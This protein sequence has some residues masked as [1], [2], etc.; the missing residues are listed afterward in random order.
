MRSFIG[1]LRNTI[2]VVGQNVVYKPVDL[3]GRQ[4]NQYAV[5]PHAAP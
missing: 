3:V 5:R 1:E 4:D 2:P